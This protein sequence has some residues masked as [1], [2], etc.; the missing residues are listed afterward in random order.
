MANVVLSNG[1]T[2]QGAGYAT[3]DGYI[4][5]TIDRNDLT[6]NHKQYASKLV[7]TDTTLLNADQKFSTKIAGKALGDV[8]ETGLKERRSLTFGSKKGVYQ[9]EIG[10]E[11]AMSYLFSQWAKQAKNLQ[12][13][14]DSIQAEMADVMSQV[15]DLVFGYD[16]RYAEELV[17]VLANGF[18]IT[19]TE[20]PGSATPTG[21]ELFSASHTTG[22]NLVTGPSYTSVTVGATQLQSAIDKLKAMKDENGKKIVAPREPLVLYCSRS[23]EVFWRQVINNESQFSAL[24]TNAAVENVF[25]FRGNIVKIEVVDLLGD[26]DAAGNTIGGDDYWFVANPTYLRFAKALRTYRL[27][28]PRIK[29]YENEPTDEIMT[30]IRAVVGADHYNAQL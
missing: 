27:Y 30:A 1:I 21:L 20:G 18:S 23:R 8:S 13:A 7:Y 17:K 10:G 9:K 4:V 29:T 26:L 25:R 14:S 3:L 16:V 5:E 12:G 28:E 24:G 15:K 11:F 6:E 22:S 19:A 2:Y